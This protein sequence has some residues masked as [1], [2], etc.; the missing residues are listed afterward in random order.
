MRNEVTQAYAQRY[1]MT[2]TLVLGCE[3]TCYVK[4]WVPLKTKMKPLQLFP[5]KPPMLNK[6]SMKMTMKL[7]PKKKINGKPEH[8]IY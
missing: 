2:I 6:Q 7:F 3:V 8:P 1:E 4:K 5:G